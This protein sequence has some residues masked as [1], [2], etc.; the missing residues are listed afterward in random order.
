MPQYEIHGPEIYF[1]GESKDNHGYIPER[2]LDRSSGKSLKNAVSEAL[3]FVP[4]FISQHYGYGI[5]LTHEDTWV[6]GYTRADAL[7]V[8]EEWPVE[9]GVHFAA[10]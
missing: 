4:D 1:Y 5:F 2:L 9:D 8:S 6:F 7:I 10:A 3:G